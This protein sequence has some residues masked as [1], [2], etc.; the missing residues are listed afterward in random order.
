[1]CFRRKTPADT[2]FALS[3]VIFSSSGLIFLQEKSQKPGSHFAAYLPVSLMC[4]HGVISPCVSQ[5]LAHAPPK[6]GSVWAADQRLCHVPCGECSCEHGSCLFKHLRG[7]GRLL[8][9]IHGNLRPAASSLSGAGPFPKHLTFPNA[10]KWG[11]GEGG[12][13]AGM[14]GQGWR[15][16]KK[17]KEEGRAEWR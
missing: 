14:R 17:E 11:G 10:Q 8:G 9:N 7:N 16:R 12:R 15:R 3:R 5:G 4:P 13:W 6:P 1:M 2:L